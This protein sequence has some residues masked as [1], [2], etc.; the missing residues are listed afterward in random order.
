MDFG[1]ERKTLAPVTPPA[2]T[3]PKMAKMR[4]KI[5]KMRPKMAKMRPKMA[6]M[7]PKMAKIKAFRRLM[8]F[9]QDQIYTRAQK[10][11][12]KRFGVNFGALLSF[13]LPTL[14]GPIRSPG[15]EPDTSKTAISPLRNGHFCRIGRARALF[16]SRP[17]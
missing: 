8:I 10:W 14:F 15:Q 5:A 4:P 11:H 9:C 2:K 3:R 16:F 12:Q 7:A 13:F 17:K 6:K 1:R